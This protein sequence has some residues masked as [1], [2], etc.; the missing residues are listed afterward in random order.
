MKHL[1]IVFIALVIVN[2][3][4]S[5]TCQYDSIFTYE[6][7]NIRSEEINQIDINQETPVSIDIIEQQ[8]KIKTIINNHYMKLEEVYHY[9]YDNYSNLKLRVDSSWITGSKEIVVDS[10]RFNYVENKLVQKIE[11]RNSSTFYPIVRYTYEYIKDTIVESKN[12]GKNMTINK[13]S[14]YT[15]DD[16]IS[17]EVMCNINK[18]GYTLQK[19]DSHDE[20]FSIYSCDNA[21]K[22]S[23]RQNRFNK[24]DEC[25]RLIEKK[26]QYEGKSRYYNYKTFVYK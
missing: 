16:L 9:Y 14:I 2:N 22:C 21:G 7:K 17:K 4:Y 10:I 26:A 1:L 3:L 19:F 5:Q 11:Y 8:L 24:Y 6:F 20:M 18:N 15:D 13:K 23:I 12:Y 25:D